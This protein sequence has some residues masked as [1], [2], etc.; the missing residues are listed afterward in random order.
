MDLF[1]APSLVSLSPEADAVFSRPSTP[2][3]ALPATPETCQ[4]GFIDRDLHGSLEVPNGATLDVEA[5]SHHAGDAPDL[6]LDPALEALWKAF[7]P[8]QRGPGVHILTGPVEVQGAEDGMA[9]AVRIDA[10]VPRHPYGAN[11][12]AHWG[13]LY[14]TFRKERITIYSLDHEG[15]EADGEFPLWARPEFAFD[16]TGRPL[17]DVPGFVSSPASVVREPVNRDVRVP[18]RPHFGVLGVAPE[19]PGRLSTVPPGPFG[20]NVDNRRFGPGATVFLPVRRAGAGLYFGDPHFGQGD[21][22]ICGTAIEAS[23]SATVRV[24]AV[25]DLD[26]RT[27]LLETVDAWYTH[28][29][30]ATLDEALRMAADEMLTL[31]TRVYGVSADEAYSLA[32]VAADFG[33]TQVVDGTLGCHGRISRHLLAR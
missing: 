6:T 30:G 19:Q 21:G 3:I 7:P 24:A 14:D 4:W 9:L 31:I 8:D 13:L 1:V 27:P 2:A 29:F 18:V 25:N 23:A 10:M 28:G 16:F 15:R 26:L 17:Y 5:I 12:A 22:E 32:S 20:G 11:C 33:V